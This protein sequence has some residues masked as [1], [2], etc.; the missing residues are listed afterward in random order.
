MGGQLP[1][2]ER[3]RFL[4]VLAPGEAFLL[5]RGHDGAVDHEGGGWVVENGVHARHSHHDAPLPGAVA[6]IQ[7]GRSDSNST[8]TGY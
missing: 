4:A 6:R 5:G 1:R 8:T 2:R 3:H 7:D